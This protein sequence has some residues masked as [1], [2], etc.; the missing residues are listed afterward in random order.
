MRLMSRTPK[1]FS[2]SR[3]SERAKPLGRLGEFAANDRLEQLV[4]GI[5]ISV[6]R[7]LGD[8]C[9]P[10]D[11]VHAR[12]VETGAQEHLTRPLD[13]LTTLR[14]AV[15][16]AAD[17][18]FQSFRFHGHHAPL[19]PPVAD[20]TVRFDFSCNNPA[21]ALSQQEMTEPFGQ[22]FVF[23]G[24]LLIMADTPNVAEPGSATASRAMT[25]PAS[26]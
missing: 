26:S 14:A 5:E 24:G 15:A 4:L 19:E 20:R 22:L 23:A 3:A 10:R 2:I 8:A 18:L 16:S 25:A 21:F 7:A 12:S 1:S 13:D 9:G 17:I 11:V 6:K